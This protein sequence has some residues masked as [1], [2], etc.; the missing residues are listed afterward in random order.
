[1]EK[2]LL[3]WIWYYHTIPT[4]YELNIAVESY[5]KYEML[6]E[7]YKHR[8]LEIYAMDPDSIEPSETVCDYV[9]NYER[10]K[11]NYVNTSL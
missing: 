6:V 10:R 7:K 2:K 9:I 1:V 8:L 5:G 11:R 4:K 3:L